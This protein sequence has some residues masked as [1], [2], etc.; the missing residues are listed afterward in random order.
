MLDDTNAASAGFPS[1]NFTL[2]AVDGASGVNGGRSSANADFAGIAFVPGYVTTTT[3]A[4]TG[5]G[6]SNT[7]TATVASAG[8]NVPT[9]VVIFSVNGTVVGQGTLNSSGVATFTDAADYGTSFI[10]AAYQGDE[11]HGPAP[12]ATPARRALR[13]RPSPSSAP[14]SASVSGITESGTVATITTTAA[15]GFV[16]GQSVAVAGESVSGYNKTYT[17]VSVTSPTTFTVTATTGVGTSGSG[18]VTLNLSSSAA[19][20]ASLLEYNS[21]GTLIETIPLS[22]AAGSAFTQTGTV[23]TAGFGTDSANGVLG[24]IVGYNAVPGSSTSNANG[25][26]GVI[27]AN[28]SIETST[29][30]SSSDDGRFDQ[31]G[32]LPQWPRLFRHDRQGRSIRSV[33]DNS[34]TAGVEISTNLPSPEAAQ[35][36][37]PA[38]YW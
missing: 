31:D 15:N 30:I 36:P 23:T 38:S 6:A 8:A 9:G 22:T 2:D 37:R 13:R 35:S 1:G 32:R 25:V 24:T 21:S 26:I 27:N 28:G 4:D 18:T 5:P 33:R 34:A 17:I 7:F 14:A 3:L 29:Q 12:G 16:A 11:G 19:A 10:T 20:P